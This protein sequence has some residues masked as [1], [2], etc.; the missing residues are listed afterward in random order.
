MFYR[1]SKNTTTINVN[2]ANKKARA[3]KEPVNK[4]TYFNDFMKR[5]VSESKASA[6]LAKRFKSDPLV[7]AAKEN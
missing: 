2:F 3:K 4:K 6:P 7:N 5:N 1:A